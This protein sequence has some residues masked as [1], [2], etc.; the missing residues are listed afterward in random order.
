MSETADV[1]VIG[2]GIVGASVA[3]YLSKEGLAVCIMDK[4]SIC[5]GCST[6]GTGSIGTGSQDFKPGDHFLLGLEAQH[7]MMS[8]IREVEE[9][10]G[11]D[12]Q[13]EQKPHISLALDEE[14]EEV[15]KE[16]IVWLTPI[17]E[18]PPQMLSREEVLKIEPRLTPNVRCGVYSEGGGVAGRVDSS[19]FTGA[20]VQS[21]EKRG[22]FVLLR[23]ATGL[24][25]DGDRVAAV[26]YPNGKVV[27]KEVVIAMG[28]WS[29]LASKWLG[30][31]TVPV[32]S[33]RGEKMYLRFD[34]PPL[35]VG[36][37]SPKRGHMMTMK[38]GIWSIGSLGGRYFD[39]PLRAGVQ[40]FD[41]KNPPQPDLSFEPSEAG[42]LELLQRAMDVLPELERAEVYQPMA[43]PRPLAADCLPLIGPVPGW[44]GVYLAT[45]HNT[46]GIHLSAI[47]GRI[48]SDLITKGRNDL[49]LS[50]DAFL[51]S[52]FA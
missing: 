10:T 4:E 38:D 33:H 21:V 23:E 32:T 42:K 51:P 18:C 37:G 13:F 39:H 34:G 52:R 25:R 41:P 24:E 50:I 15:L 48:I 46:N 6:H 47:T 3:Y 17:R 16:S 35:E 11:V 8:L 12:T 7:V 43:G 40:V 22:G 1:V 36:I 30:G 19:R 9:D 26:L 5:A 14:E 2:A 49:P 45:G 28:A 44:R 20:L 29:G 31:Y 27:C